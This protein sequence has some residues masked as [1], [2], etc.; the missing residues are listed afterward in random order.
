MLHPISC[1]ITWITA[2]FW[3]SIHRFQKHFTRVSVRGCSIIIKNMELVTMLMMMMMM[4]MMTMMLMLMMTMMLLLLLMLMMMMIIIIIIM[5]MMKKKVVMMSILPPYCKW[6][7]KPVNAVIN[8][9][10]VILIGAAC[11]ETIPVA[12][13]QPGYSE[14]EN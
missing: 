3:A 10:W 6:W 8:I 9:T 1:W 2:C 5:I 13:W 7:R 11:F 12:Q 14:S 4:M